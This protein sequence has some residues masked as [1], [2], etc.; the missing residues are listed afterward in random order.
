MQEW[1]NIFWGRLKQVKTV[2]LRCK[3]SASEWMQTRMERG[4]N[5]RLLWKSVFEEVQ[6]WTHNS[7]SWTKTRDRVKERERERGRESDTEILNGHYW[8][9]TH[10][11]LSDAN[12][13]RDP[14]KEQKTFPGN[15][16][17]TKRKKRKKNLN[18]KKRRKWKWKNILT[19]NLWREE[20]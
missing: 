13:R 3:N 11:S 4:K 15:S 20:Q 14:S 1:R 7:S 18:K 19:D 16:F 9:A 8:I 5:R 10:S 2:V 17:R 12:E 6:Q